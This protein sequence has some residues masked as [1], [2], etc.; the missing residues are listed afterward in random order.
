[1]TE[2]YITRATPNPA[3]KDRTPANQVTHDQLNGEWLEFKN[4]TQRTL[5]LD[6]VRLIHTTFDNYCGKTG[7]AVLVTFKGS[8]EAGKSLRVHT[9]SGQGYWEGDIYHF[10]AGH[11]NFVWNNRCGDVAYLR[12]SSNQNIDW[13][14]YEKNPGE[15]KVPVRVANTNKL[16]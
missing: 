5:S 10:Y 14:S 11:R 12:N 15:G 8:L 6:D 13:A 16:A 4:T 1:M 2:L 9:D 7:E 3:G